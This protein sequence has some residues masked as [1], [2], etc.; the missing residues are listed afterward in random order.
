LRGQGGN[1]TLNGRGGN[2]SLYGGAGADLL[3]GE[4]GNDLLDGGAG[5]DRLEGGIG[6]DSYLIYRGMG[7]DKIN[8]FDYTG[9]NVDTLQLGPGI[10]IDQLWFRK[11]GFWDLE[12]SIIGSNDTMTIEKW[13]FWSKGSSWESAQHVEQFH[14]DDGKVLASSQVSQLVQAMAAFAPPP[15]GQTTLPPE[16]QAALT[17]VLATSWK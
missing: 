6:N 16:Y 1:D 10:S 3:Y 5:N 13:D 4:N 15:P 8:D 9:A 12:V 7:S 2:D 17:P 14:T 11:T